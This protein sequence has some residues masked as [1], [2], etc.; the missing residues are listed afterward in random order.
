MQFL[1][2]ENQPR[3]ISASVLGLALIICASIASYTAYAIKASQDIVEVTGSAKVA[4]TSDFARWSISLEA[5][6]GVNNQADGY[7]RLEAGTEKIVTYLK[8]QGYEDVETPSPS[9]YPNYTYPQYG[10]PILTGYTVSRQIVVRSDDVAGIQSLAGSIEPLSGTGYT[11]STGMVELTYQKLPETRV[12]LLTDA[13]ADA[14]AR[15]EAIAKES[16]REV[17][18]LR[19]ASSGV[20]QVLPAGSIDISDYGMYDTQSMNKEVMVTVRAKFSPK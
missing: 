3:V 18:T 15:A 6:T 11:V 19:S 7:K 9:V 14:T 12:T 16:G 2:S 10:E 1:H 4:V 20:V 8:E 17:G 13:I 5:K